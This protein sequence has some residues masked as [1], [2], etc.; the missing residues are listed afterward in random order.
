MFR[1]QN[2]AQSQRFTADEIADRLN[3]TLDVVLDEGILDSVM[4]FIVPKLNFVETAVKVKNMEHS[5]RQEELHIQQTTKEYLGIMRNSKMDKM[6]EYV[7]FIS[8]NKVP[9]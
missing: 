5:K 2:R 7:V 1:R 6:N 9:M 4:P 3:A 8:R